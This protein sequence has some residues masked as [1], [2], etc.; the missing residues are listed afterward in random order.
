MLL[1]KK[2]NK[3][4]D[5][6]MFLIEK[7]AYIKY[8][9]SRRIGMRIDKNNIK[10]ILILLV[11]CLSLGYAYINSDL[12]INGTA[13]VKHANWDVHWANIQVTNGSVSASTPTISNQTTVNYSVVLNLPGDYYEFTVDAV[14]GGNIDAMI[15]TID[16]KLNGATI[17]ALPDY[18]KYTV[19]YSDGVAL[20]PNHQ[21]LHNTTEKY[22]VRIEYNTDIELNQI[23]ATNQDLSLQ[24]TVTYRQATD[25]AVAVVH[26]VSFAEDDWSTII[27][28]VQ[29]GNTSNYNVG[30]TKTVDM[31]SLRTHTLRIAN[32]STPS[33]CSTIGFS[34]T[35]CGFVLEFA[36]II[37]THRMNPW[38]S[39]VTTTG[40]GNIG[41]WPASEMRTYVN[42]DIYNALPSELKSGIINTTVVSGHGNTV[43]ETNFTS[44]DKLYLLSTHEVWEDV[45]GN[46]SSGINYYD[47]AYNNTRQLDYYSS[48]NVTT[49]NYSGA[50]K[51]YYWWMRSADFT[52]NYPFYGV[53]TN[54]NW[55][56]FYSYNPGGVSPAFRIG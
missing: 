10:I 45:D 33:E 56:N 17:T 15:D 54:G 51:Q 29:S 8:T 36:D 30:D 48:Q 6:Q 26:P 50:I 2:L 11:V 40:N 42:S 27:A 34:Q 13:Q 14:N 37:T 31:G 39:S 4:S 7:N 38:D 16:S 55:F 22:K 5:I 3:T 1:E 43:G 19:T 49:S 20:Q 35:A 52:T 12:N 41:G 46:T 23:P 25:A 32:K 44:T 24:F 18:L 53:N 28:A 9:Y 47:T 21:L